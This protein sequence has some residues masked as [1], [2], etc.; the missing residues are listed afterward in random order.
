MGQAPKRDLMQDRGGT[1]N[2]RQ[3]IWVLCLSYEHW[4]S[5]KDSKL[6]LTQSKLHSENI[7]M[8]SG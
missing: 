5:L 7:T 6:G 8:A 2:H 3:S 1:C 4:E